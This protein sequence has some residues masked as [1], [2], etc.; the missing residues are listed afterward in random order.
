[1]LLGGLFEVYA[2]FD[3]FF[4]YLGIVDTFLW[5]YFGVP[6]VLFFGLFF[7]FKA[8]WFHIRQCKFIAHSF[9]STLKSKEPLYGISP[10]KAFFASIA[11]CISIGNVVGV[12]AAVNIGGPG[13]LVWMWIASILGMVI[14]YSEIYLGISHRVKNKTLNTYDGGPMYYLKK[15]DTSL[16]LSK[17]FCVALCIYGAEVYMFRVVTH[18]IV[19]TWQWNHMAVVLGLLI[20]VLWATKKGFESVGHISSIVIPLFLICFTSVSFWVFIQKSH[21]IL[22]TFKLIFTSAFTGHA[23]IGAFAGSGLMLTVAQGL[24]RACYSADI[25]VGCASVIMSEAE[26]TTTKER[27]AAMAG[28][29]STFIDTFIISTISFLLVTVS[30]LWH[31]GVHESRMIS[32]ALSPYIPHMNIIWPL[33]I[34]LLGFSSIISYFAA[35]QKAAYFLGKQRGKSIYTFYA[36][37]AFLLF[38]FVGSEE[39]IM[40]IMSTCGIFLLLIN[41]YGIV[42]LRNSISFDLSAHTHQTETL[43]KKNPSTTFKS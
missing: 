16:F 38:S 18:T 6:I 27:Q 31:Q 7:S 10:L 37:C 20:L 9:F 23:A 5:E 1:M 22:P 25:G 3:S 33:F 40:T 34:F 30:G 17:A 35:G 39:H 8:R 11:G 32:T 4:Q 28:I 14:K 15:V 13:A 29:F 41:V 24:K 36:I 43:T 2:A 21:L 26:I 19:E 12:C 42:K